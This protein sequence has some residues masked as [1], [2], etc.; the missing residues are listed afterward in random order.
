MPAPTIRNQSGTPAGSSATIPQPVLGN[1][2]VLCNF[3][4]NS[5]TTGASD[6]A[7]NIWTHQLSAADSNMN[8]LNVFTAPVI[9]TG[10]GTNTISGLTD[11]VY[12]V[13]EIQGVGATPIDGSVTSGTFSGSSGGTLTASPIT[14]S[15][16]TDL[17][18]SFAIDQETATLTVNT[19]TLV[20]SGS[21]VD[22]NIVQQ[23]TTSSTGPY[24][25]SFNVPTSSGE[26]AVIIA[27]AI[28][29]IAGPTINTQPSS[30]STYVGSTAT[31]TVSATTS[32]GS[33]SYQ[34]QKFI[35][36]SWSNVGTN[37]SSYTT[38]NTTFADQGDLF[39]VIIT[40]S[41]GSI[42]S[43]TAKLNIIGIA[44]LMW[45]SC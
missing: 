31:F 23:H 11:G 37:S 38:G 6:T 24:A 40:D 16:A 14:T 1:F 12:W 25:E 33:L 10:S 26:T 43:S 35:S 36:G 32:G 17:I 30:T 34:W 28:A 9:S 19:G 20:A 7:G 21:N 22:F 13:A 39:Q 27:I 4:F 29:G 15:V 8:W 44:G 2:L 41:N 18:L 3:N 42:T 5:R 45:I